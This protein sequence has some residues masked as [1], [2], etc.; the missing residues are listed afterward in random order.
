MDQLQHV[1]LGA[2]PGRLRS[3][4]GTTYGAVL[5]SLALVL[6]ACG[7]GE[8]ES[9]ADTGADSGVAAEEPETDAGETEAEG[10][11]ESESGDAF[12]AGKRITM[13]VPYGPGGGTDITARFVAP[14]L[15]ANTPGNPSIQVVNQEGAN[16]LIGSNAFA[17]AEPDGESLLMSGA[18]TTFNYVLGNADVEYAYSDW[19]PILGSPQSNIVYVASGIGVEEP[20]D[21]PNAT[22]QYVLPA[23][24]VEGSD[25]V[26]VI[27]LDLLGLD[28]DVVSGY[29][30]GGA[31]RIA[32]EQGEANINGDT[33]STYYANVEPLVEE[34]SAIPMYSFGYIDDSGEVVRDP[35][36]PELPHIGEVYEEIH[37]NPPEGEM[38]D[39]YE[40][41]LGSYV[42]QKILWIHNDAP[43]EAIEALKTGAA[44]SL[45][46]P[47]Y[48]AKKGEVL[49]GYELVV[50]DALDAAVA[51]VA[52]P[53][54]EV[55]DWTYNYLLENYDIDIRNR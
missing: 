33:T 22:E 47:D 49:K 46:D 21:L 7:G 11:A 53:P 5:L 55:L 37:G 36:A 39:A 30:G 8:T 31:A 48:E 15:E 20:A 51:D 25:L 42:M 41:L 32:F 4:R 18:A 19:T 12:Y 13:T 43:P 45:N 23:Q 28:F 29:D 14:L 17:A 10:E 52:N 34:G 6:S 1:G 35:A 54:Q 16:T 3:G 24:S 26:R 2:V 9:E 27:T 44:E 50:G 38:W 40:V